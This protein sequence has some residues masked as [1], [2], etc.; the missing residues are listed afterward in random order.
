M[1]NNDSAPPGNPTPQPSAYAA[2]YDDP[3]A[4]FDAP[5]W[6]PEQ[7]TRLE[8]EWR[9]L[10]RSF[11]Y[12]PH[13]TVQP[14]KGD[15][16]HEYQIDYRLTTLVIDDAGQLQYAQGASVHVWLPPEFPEHPP[17]LRPL[18]G[19][20]HPNVSWEGFHLES[21][22]QV[23]DTLVTLVRRIGDLLTYRIFDPNMV[24]NAAAMDWLH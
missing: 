16:P 10:Q 6:S 8:G 22:W 20:F 18:V 4:D 1:W 5:H 19:L 7:V 17:V 15:P 12:H 2:P 3:S 21:A 14:L 9:K 11:A 23:N 13:V 24:V